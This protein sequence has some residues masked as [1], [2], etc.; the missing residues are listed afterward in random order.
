MLTADLLRVKIDGGQVFPKTLDPDAKRPM[1]LSKTLIEIF[2]SCIGKTCKELDV[3]LE[4]AIGDA[5]DFRIRRGLIKLLKGDCSTFDV[6]SSRPSIELRRKVFQYAMDHAPIVLEPDL[7]HKVTRDVVME[8]IGAQEN[9]S[10]EDVSWALYADLPE[11]H[12]LIDFNEPTP[13]WLIQRYNLALSQALLYRC[14]EMRL[15]VYRNTP[16]KYKQLFKFIKFFQ[17]M[18]QITGDLDAGYEIV[19]DGPVS[20]FRFSEKYGLKLATF[21]PALL[22]CT[23]WKMRA[24]VIASYGTKHKFYLDDGCGLVSHYKDHTVYD[25]QL[26]ET[27]AQRFEKHLTEWKLERETEI[28][29]LKDTVFI[30]DFAFRHPDGRTALLEIVGFW[31]PD[32]LRRKLEKIQRANRP[33]IIIAISQSLRVSEETLEKLPG[34]AFFFKTRIDPKSVVERLE[35]IPRL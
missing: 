27:F 14:Q 15:T 3:A 2:K 19:L 7:I 4:E 24:E 34:H 23:K 32:Y 20:M 10:P 30:P 6:Q 21:L 18:H 9:L 29:N 17:L 26:E 5:L 35:M 1:E 33:D 25:S 13:E 22:L 12:I 31:H 11:N 8:S 28:I 16:T